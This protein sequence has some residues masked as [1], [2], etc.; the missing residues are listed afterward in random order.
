ME[1]V[2]VPADVG[3]FTDPSSPVYTVPN[4]PGL[5]DIVEQKPSNEEISN[6][7]PSLDLFNGQFLKPQPRHLS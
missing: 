7:R 2:P 1:D 4:S 6:V 5:N 3:G